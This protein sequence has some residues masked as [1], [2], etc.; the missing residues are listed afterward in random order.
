MHLASIMFEWYHIAER[1]FQMQHDAQTAAAPCYVDDR[2]LSQHTPYS[3][4]FWQHKRTAGGGPSI[5]SA[6]AAYSTNGPMLSD[7]YRRK[8]SVP[9]A[10]TELCATLMLILNKPHGA[11]GKPF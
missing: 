8:P 6:G 5:T 4:S 3:R 10:S 9:P 11:T 2:Y 7:G 1:N